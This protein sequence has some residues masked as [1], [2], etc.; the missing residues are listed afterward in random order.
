[1]NEPFPVRYGRNYKVVL[2]IVLP[3]LLI[4]P[5][6][7]TMQGLK[8][9]AEWKIWLII[10]SFL[11]SIIALSVWLVM[12]VYPPAYLS[13]NNDVVSLTFDST[14]FLSPNDFRFEI[15]EISSFTQHEFGGAEYFIFK[16]INPR[17]KFQISASSNALE[18]LLSFNEAM[19]EISEKLNQENA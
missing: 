15:S 16:T 10:F 17:R 5:F 11:F 18:D 6:I 2:A 13:I 14:R 12:R 7:L 19:V 4:I 3:C 8:S 1:M 9:Q